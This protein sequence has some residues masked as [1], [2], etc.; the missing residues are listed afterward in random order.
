M[1]ILFAST[2]GQLVAYAN[3]TKGSPGAVSIY[4]IRVVTGAL[5]AVSTRT[6][7]AGT[8]DQVPPAPIKD[9][10]TN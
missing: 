4:T 6:P 10:R 3:A 2:T 9:L 5:V 7:P 1:R 8:P